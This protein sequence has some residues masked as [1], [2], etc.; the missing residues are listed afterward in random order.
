MF[1]CSIC[2]YLVYTGRINNKILFIILSSQVTLWMETSSEPMLALTSATIIALMVRHRNLIC[3]L[4]RKDS[5]GTESHCFIKNKETYNFIESRRAQK[6]YCLETILNNSRY[7]TR[8]INLYV[9]SGKLG[10][11]NKSVSAQ[12]IIPSDLR[13]CMSS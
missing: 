1:V 13:D 4:P 2:I 3:I 9:S 12:T 8:L 11:K 7:V 5:T 10:R 6:L